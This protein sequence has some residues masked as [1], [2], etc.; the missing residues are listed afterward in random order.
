MNWK[1]SNS[2][3]YHCA[4]KHT[5]EKLYSSSHYMDWKNQPNPFR[6]YDGVEKIEL[7]VK[8]LDDK[9][10]YFDVISRINKNDYTKGLSLND[11][12]KLL[13]FS[14]SISAWKEIP[15]SGERWSLRVNPS[16][17][18]LQPTEL[19]L[20]SNG[21][22]GLK[23]G[24]Y[25][26]FVPE[27][28]LERR[29]DESILP[30][31]L[32][33]DGIPEEFS[34]SSLVIILT[35]IFW[36]QAWKYQNRALRYCYHDM[37]HALGAINFAASALGFN[38]YASGNFKDE[39]IKRLLALE[40]TGEVPVLI[41]PIN[42]LRP[43]SFIKKR[44]AVKFPSNVLGLPNKLSDQETSYPL[45]ESIYQSSCC[46]DTDNLHNEFKENKSI[47][48]EKGEGVNWELSLKEKVISDFFQIVRKRRSAVNFDN[49]K[50]MDLDHLKVI[51]KSS[52]I[53]FNADFQQPC[54]IAEGK[55]CR[56]FTDIYL[57]VHR[58]K[59]F[60]AGLYY[61][62]RLNCRITSIQRGDQR[63]AARNLSLGQDI[64]SN[65]CVV[66]SL[67]ADLKLAYDLY[68]DRGYRYVHIESGY[69]G[70]G[71]Y[72]TAEALGYNGTGIGAFF[73]DDVNKY[74]KLPEGKEVIYHFTIGQAVE[75]LRLATKKGYS[76]E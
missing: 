42:S 34:K 23:D 72:L 55:S 70:Q 69:I 52:T 51:L 19:H 22:K 17:G 2:Y 21:I 75:D 7:P 64:A 30:S 73:D 66:F 65:S 40:G 62:D 74:L 18:N 13:F 49:N 16:A 50:F 54:N 58:V 60:S 26:Y 67:I 76:F 3:R 43:M 1:E 48:G 10:S 63:S 53:G 27:H 46:S 12:S 9:S 35:T 37:G 39:E 45:I 29:G 24:L 25:H 57:F 38:C 31:L 47:C 32:S 5:V 14:M 68:G 8:N 41:V 33:C 61:Y 4:T 44:E 11:L 20:L 71:L 56:F 15:E 6:F 59:D 36:R 28:N